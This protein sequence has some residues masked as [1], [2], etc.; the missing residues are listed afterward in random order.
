MTATESL[1]EEIRDFVDHADD[2]QL[3]ILKAI[4][5]LAQNKPISDDSAKE[6][7]SL[8]KELKQ[9]ISQGIKESQ[10][11]KTIPLEEIVGQYRKWLQNGRVG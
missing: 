11:G 8:P 6:W 2:K 3:R 7:N 9:A 4:F 10:S 5:E 1:R